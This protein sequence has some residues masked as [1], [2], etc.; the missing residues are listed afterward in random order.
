MIKLKDILKEMIDSSV[1]YHATY[2]PLLRSIKLHGLD[3]TKSK[4]V[5]DDSK[6]GYVYLAKDKEVATSYA[7]SS[8][9]VP[10]SYL[11]DIVILHIDAT[12]LDNSKL[13]IDK[14]VIDNVGDT[15][16]YNGVI[17]FSYVIKVEDYF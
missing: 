12:K 1:L 7:E 14:N 9:N 15:L 6:I 13:S 5:W 8:D 2:K 11:D 10:E 4:R 16:E 17:P 3:N